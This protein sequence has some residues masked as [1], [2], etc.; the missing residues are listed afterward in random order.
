M[1]R[2]HADGFVQHEPT[3]DVA[4][5]AFAAG[6]RCGRGAIG[7]SK[8]TGRRIHTSETII[9]M[10]DNLAVFA[11]CMAGRDGSQ[12]CR[13]GALFI[14]AAPEIALDRGCSQKLLDPF[15]FVESL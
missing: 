5:L 3:M 10:S 4:F 2:S 9:H 15:R 12:R 11:M 6:G 13:G 14:V 8:R 1:G 7:I